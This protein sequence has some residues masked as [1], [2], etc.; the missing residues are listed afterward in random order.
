M[1]PVLWLY[2]LQ[3]RRSYAMLSYGRMAVWLHGLLAYGR[4]SLIPRLTR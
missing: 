4:A 1:I 2:S 3:S